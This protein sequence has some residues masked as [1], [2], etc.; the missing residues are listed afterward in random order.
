[1]SPKR[2]Q[3]KSKVIKAETSIDMKARLK[4]LAG[5]FFKLG[6]I[7]Y[8]GPAAHIAMMRKEVVEDR[9]WMTE[10]HF[11][12]LM[13]ATNLIPGPNSTELTMHCG[14]ERAGWRGLFVAGISFILPAVLSTLVLAWFYVE[15]GSI[16]EVAPVFA[17]IR[18]AVIAI[19]AGAILKLGKKALKSVRLGLIGALILL[20]A[21]F[22]LSEVL[23]ILLGGLLSLLVGSLLSRGGL[24]THSHAWLLAVP[25]STKVVGSWPLFWT[26]LKVGSILFGSGYVLVAYLQGEL[27]D[28]LGW[29]TENELLDAI[30]IGQFTPGP[31]L[32]TATFVGYQVDG[33]AGAAAA[34]IGIFLPSFLFVLLLNPLVPMLRRSSAA[35]HFLDGVNIGAVAIMLSVTI[36]LVQD[37]LVDWQSVVVCS[38][39]M[40]FT[41]GPIKLSSVYIVVM[42]M[43][44]GYLLYLL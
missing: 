5:L 20:S 35:S 3:V 28:R 16:P 26:F 31:V 36:G 15:Y 10:A 39:A 8:G 12:D 25:A 6:V 17:G 11:L 2:W 24:K 19:I 22:G 40:A 38:M 29:L 9:Q 33:F 21:F 13:G 42:G 7:G 1:M 34:T 32:S 27:V 37:T 30:A 43:I 23:A 18:A 14:H 44:A 41:F 4:E